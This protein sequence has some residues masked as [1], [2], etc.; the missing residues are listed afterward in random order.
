MISV[1]LPVYNVEKYISDCIESLMVQTSENFEIIVVN[2][3]TKDDSAKI[4]ERILKDGKIPYTVKTTKNGG[5]SA[6]RNTGLSMASGDYAVMV[7]S[8]DTVS[9]DFI[10]DYEK[11]IKKYPDSDV[12]FCDYEVISEKNGDYDK[13]ECAERV[14]SASDAQ[15]EFLNRGIRFLLPTMAVKM[16][17]L[18]ECGF[19]FDE[20][21]RYSEDV[22]FIWRALAYT[23][24][25][26]V[27]LPK[28]NYH[29]YLHGGSTMT[30]SGVE[31][32]LTGCGGIQRLYDEIGERLCEPV[33]SQITDKWYFAMLH[34][35]AKMLKYSD[36]KTL[37]AS[38]GAENHIKRLTADGDGKTKAVAGVMSAS[39]K[40]GYYLMRRF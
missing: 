30:A 11:L 39:L 9:P 18:R 15:K 31:K 26:I 10:S 37:Y 5:V 34:G 23:G 24:G 19:G 22:Q 29:Y 12:L 21:V 1:I 20:K 35:A 14:L 27:F 16:S 3:G 17:W 28:K 7:D 33:K 4:A 40:C 25:D 13:S 36:Y 38:S 32:I 8:D 6:A 2:D